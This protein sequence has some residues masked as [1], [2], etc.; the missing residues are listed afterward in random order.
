ML[1]NHY[2]LLG[3]QP[4][5][6]AGQIK[7]AYRSMAKR[8]HPDTNQGSEAA[9]ELFRQLNEA[10]R[11]LTDREL[12]TAYDAKLFAAEQAAQLRKRT[13]Q[14]GRQATAQREKP[15][16]DPQE[17]FNRFLNTLLDALLEEPESATPLAASRDRPTQKK[18]PTNLRQQ[19]DFDFYYYLAMEKK[20][21][22]YACGSDGVYRRA[23]STKSQRVNNAAAGFSRVPGSGLLMILLSSLWGALNL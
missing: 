20:T 7:T 19:P 13:Q 5:A 3:L 10:Y 6:D 18:P 16:R 9:A 11:V 17:K 4:D 15:T 14:K 12:R 1:M 8:F 22:A 2:L 21:P 23:K